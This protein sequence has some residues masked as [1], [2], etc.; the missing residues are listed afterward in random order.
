MRDITAI[1][2]DARREGIT[3]AAL[4]R[5]AGTCTKTLWKIRAG[6]AAQ[7]PVMLARLDLALA[8][9]KL[10]QAAHGESE[11][12]LNVAYRA[13]MALAA[14]GLGEQPDLAARLI[15]PAA[16]AYAAG[17]DASARKSAADA[18]L[19]QAVGLLAASPGQAAA[20]NPGRRATGSAQWLAAAEARRL[21]L[22]LLNAACGF[23]QAEIARAAGMTRQAV[24]LAV[25][26]AEERREDGAYDALA[27]RL[28]AMVTGDGHAA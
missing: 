15:A 7:T 11:T 8:R 6:K 22:Y 19:R 1:L 26:A 4:C 5:A 28:T 2:D 14:K 10:G 27:E 20:A 23:R 9:L 13:A 24:S 17:H 21:G 16:L 25:R 18:R 12:A 3:P